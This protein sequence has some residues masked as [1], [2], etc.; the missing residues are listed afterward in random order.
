[1]ETVF[2][3]LAILILKHV[4]VD[5][6]LQPREIA[7][8]KGQ[9]KIILTVHTVAHWIATTVILLCINAF[10]FN[11]PAMTLL[12]VPLFDMGTHWIIDF[13]STRFI[14][15]KGLTVEDKMLWDVIGIDQAFH[16]LV[17][18]IITIFIT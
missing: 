12:F 6:I 3:I 7:L 10:W 18:L 8:G 11:L 1:M 16:H 13:C 15:R 17:Y 5:F 4:V 9:S 14:R 2:Y